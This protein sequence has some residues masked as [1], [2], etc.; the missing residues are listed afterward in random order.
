MAARQAVL[1]QPPASSEV[2]TV[3]S[4]HAGV[5]RHVPNKGP[6]KRCWSGEKSCLNFGGVRFVRFVRMRGLRPNR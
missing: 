3:Q 1:Q 5:V 4:E 2:L 6:E